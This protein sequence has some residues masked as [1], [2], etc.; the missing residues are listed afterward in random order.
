MAF[1]NYLLLNFTKGRTPAKDDIF[2]K[3]RQHEKYEKDNLDKA[4]IAKAV[5]ESFAAV[6]SSLASKSDAELTVV[7]DFFENK[8]STAGMYTII[9]AHASEHLGQLIAYARMCGVK[10]PWSQ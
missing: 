4:G 1:G 5:K 10:P 2:N 7:I 3:I 6:R 8:K 9:A